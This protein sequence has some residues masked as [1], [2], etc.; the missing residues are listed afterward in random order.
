LAVATLAFI[1]LAAARLPL[2]VVV[3]GLVPISIAMASRD[4]ATRT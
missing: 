3:L 1:G 4:S 2:L